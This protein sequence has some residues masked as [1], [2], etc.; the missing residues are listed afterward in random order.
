MRSG[1]MER[2]GAAD[3]RKIAGGRDATGG[4]RKSFTACSWRMRGSECSAAGNGGEASEFERDC[5]ARRNGGSF[6][7]GALKARPVL[8]EFEHGLA[9]VLRAFQKSRG[10][11]EQ[12]FA[13]EPRVGVARHDVAGA[14]ADADGFT[15]LGKLH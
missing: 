3:S 13:G 1:G 15:I 11:G 2:G 8:M 5:V 9:A 4:E 6:R 7:G 12:Q 10:A 14:D